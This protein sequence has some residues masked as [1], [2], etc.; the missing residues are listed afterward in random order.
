MGCAAK[1]REE[2]NLNNV[3]VELIWEALSRKGAV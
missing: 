3:G 2:I 1:E